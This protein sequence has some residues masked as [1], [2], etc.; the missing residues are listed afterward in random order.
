MPEVYAY[1]NTH[2]EV[3]KSSS[4]GAFIAICHAFEAIG[5]KGN[6]T[7]YGAAFDEDMN[8]VHKRVESAGECRIFQGSKYVKSAT[9]TVY[10]DAARDLSEGRYVLFSGT[11]CQ[12]AALKKTLEKNGA[13]TEKLLTV[14][15]IC[16]GTPKK[17]FWND[18]KAWLEDKTSGKLTEYSFRYKPQGWKAY[19]AYARFDNG[20][21]LINTAETSVF[22]VAHMKLYSIAAGCFSCPFSNM[23]RRGD[24]TLGDY[25][26][27]E[28]AVP[29]IPAKTGV[30]LIL[31][32]NPRAAAL[33]ESL[34]TEGAYLVKTEDRSFITRQH[35][36]NY[37]TKKPDGYDAFWQFYKENGFEATIRKYLGYGTKYRLAFA[38]KKLVRKTPLIEIYRNR[39]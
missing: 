37:P 5:G 17:E 32:N 16:H 1:K 26:G 38:V 15:I 21:T 18:Y 25:W 27:V 22:S 10:S 11:P 33:V 19:P 3:M 7:F 35:N 36:L 34:K 31:V 9:E 13:D 8:V 39:K 24:I 6:T 23:N 12:I 28:K 30:S 2:D 20:K 29:E 14:D 4:G